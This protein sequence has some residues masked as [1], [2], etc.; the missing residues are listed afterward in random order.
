MSI[1]RLTPLNIYLGQ[2]APQAKEGDM[3]YD[4]TTNKL[5]IFVEGSWNDL[6]FLSNVS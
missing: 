6:A 4:E 1:K 3:Y 2:V 5:R